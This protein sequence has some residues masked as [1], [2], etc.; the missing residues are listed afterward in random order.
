M[1]D[2]YILTHVFSPY[3]LY[4]KIDVLSRLGIF[5]NNPNLQFLSYIYKNIDANGDNVFEIPDL[6][7]PLDVLLITIGYDVL[8]IIGESDISLDNINKIKCAAMKILH[9]YIMSYDEIPSY[10]KKDIDIHYYAV[11]SEIIMN[12]YITEEIMTGQIMSSNNNIVRISSIWNYISRN[13]IKSYNDLFITKLLTTNY[14]RLKS[15]NIYDQ[16][17]I[18]GTSIG[19][20]YTIQKAYELF[21]SYFFNN[22]LNVKEIQYTVPLELILTQTNFYGMSYIDPNIAINQITS[23]NFLEQ[24]INSIMENIVEKIRIVNLNVKTYREI[25]E[26]RNIDIDPTLYYY[27]TMSNIMNGGVEQ[28]NFKFDS[29]ISDNSKVFVNN[30]KIQTNEKCETY[31]YLARILTNNIISK[32]PTDFVQSFLRRMLRSTQNS[33]LTRRDKRF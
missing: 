16:I 3:T 1:G 12:G 10:S 17:V 28:L 7:L 5:P 24:A 14:Y 11:S 15:N 25:L 13:Q 6:L 29:Y 32:L 20:G 9:L 2:D 30:V 21:V 22:R 4:N 33:S 31:G 23:G 18:S 8:C 26:V 19:L 27:N